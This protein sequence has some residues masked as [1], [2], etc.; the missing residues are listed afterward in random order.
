MALTASEP[1]KGGCCDSA[2]RALCRSQH[3]PFVGSLGTRG[4]EFF[5][6][7]LAFLWGSL[8][9]FYLL[10]EGGSLTMMACVSG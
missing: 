5:M 3:P 9:H 2:L 1:T 6:L 10:F 8:F 7:N 4:K